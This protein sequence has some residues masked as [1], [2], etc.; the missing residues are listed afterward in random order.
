MKRNDMHTKHIPTV[1]ATACI[2]HMYEVH[3]D[4]LNDAWLQDIVQSG[5]NYS[6]PPPIV[7]RDRCM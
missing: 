2:L 5:G 7:C 4:K 3:D 1:V 6:S